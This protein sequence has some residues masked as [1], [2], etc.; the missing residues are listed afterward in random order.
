VRDIFTGALTNEL[1]RRPAP[2]GFV[3]RLADSGRLWLIAEEDAKKRG[4]GLCVVRT[5]AARPF[6]IEAPHTFFDRGTLDIALLAFERLEARALLIN[7]M[8]RSAAETKKERA[9]DAREGDSPQDL[10]HAQKSFFST[11]HVELTRAD[12]EIV[13]VQLHGFKDE[14]APGVDVVV[15]AAKTRGDAR[16]VAASLGRVVPGDRV[17]LYPDQIDDLGGTK[18]RQTELSRTAKVA[19]VHVEISATLRTRLNEDQG[20]A[21]RFVDALGA[22]RSGDAR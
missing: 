10:A 3:G 11:S 15:S 4:A 16:S 19:F 17:R 8:R 14:R 21:A 2:P 12:P 1:P 13:V 22:A 9:E 7:T 5:G 20:F 6:L 18:N